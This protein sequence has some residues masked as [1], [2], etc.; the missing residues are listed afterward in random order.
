MLILSGVGLSN[1]AVGNNNKFSDTFMTN[2][3]TLP[4][5][6]TLIML[7]LSGVGMCS[8]KHSVSFITKQLDAAMLYDTAHVIYV[9]C[10]YV[11]YET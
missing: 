8:M 2:N 7:F 9:R 6:L 10:W 5:C 3:L 4:C 11:L 1:I